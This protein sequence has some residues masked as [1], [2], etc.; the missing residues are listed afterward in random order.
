[1]IFKDMR[2]GYPVYML[3]KTDGE[4]KAVTGKVTMVSQPRFPQMQPGSQTQTIGMVVD[5]TIESEG[6]TK[7]YEIPES[8][9]VVNAGNLVL[10]VDK[11]GILREVR[12]IK[13]RSEQ[14]IKD[15]AKHNKNIEDCEKVMVEWDTS[16]ADKKENEAR[17]AGIEN[18]MKD[19]KGVINKLIDKLGN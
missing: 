11:E 15:V 1:M 12:A 18:E 10:S 2:Q 17:F 8:S 7:T 13:S 16:F 14:A 4:I 3:D 9:S 19:L 5:V 6:T